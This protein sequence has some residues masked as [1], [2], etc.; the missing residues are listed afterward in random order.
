MKKETLD[1]AAQKAFP[2]TDTNWSL[3]PRQ[4][5]FKSG[6]KWL[7]KQSQKIVPHDATDIE[8]FAIK[9]DENG[10]LFAYIGYKISNGNFEFNIVPFTDTNNDISYNNKKLNINSDNNSKTKDM[11]D[12]IAFYFKLLLM[13]TILYGLFYLMCYT[14]GLT[15]DGVLLWKP[16][17]VTFYTISVFFTFIIPVSIQIFNIIKL[18][19]NPKQN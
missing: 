6:A 9:A 8:V 16:L 17:V 15:N 3:K 5:A 13:Q 4:E 2:I 7:I 11:K 14:D 19:I 12:M 18:I 10:K 1:E